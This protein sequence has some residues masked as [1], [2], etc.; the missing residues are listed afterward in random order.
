[1]QN[2]AATHQ[3]ILQCAGIIMLGGISSSHA[4]FRGLWRKYTMINS[5]QVLN[6]LGYA[7]LGVEE[8]D[9]LARTH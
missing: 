5:G 6:W 2:F 3:E 1:L 4:S 9:K 8:E 7:K